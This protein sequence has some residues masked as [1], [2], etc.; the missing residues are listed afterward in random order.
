MASI[1]HWRARLRQLRF[2]GYGG[3][4]IRTHRSM[5]YLHLLRGELVLALLLPLAFNL[6][7]LLALDELV[8]F[9]RALLEFWAS[10]LDF[11]A[12]VTMRPFDLGYY[13][14][15]LP[16]VRVEAPLPSAALWWGTAVACLLLFLLSYLVKPERFLPLIYILRAV[17]LIQATALLY[18]AF[19]PASFPYRLEDYVANSLMIGILLLAL[20]PWILGATYYVFDFGLTQK[21]ALTLMTQL[22][23]VLA[24]PLQ[25][26]LHASIIHHA[27]LLFM[28]LFYLV[29][30]LFFDI[31]AFVAFYSLGMSWRPNRKADF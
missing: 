18:F 5:Y 22:F 10:R 23:F 28:P 12:S 11:A 21:I 19:I 31:M 8:H 14:L 26:L 13:D 6:L 25:Y 30:G 16:A 29:F 20:I 3:A 7:M 24:I 15:W 17:L 2:R 4:T 27:S 1:E 9:W